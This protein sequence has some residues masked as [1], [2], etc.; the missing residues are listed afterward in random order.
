M[1]TEKMRPAF[2]A[3]MAESGYMTAK[4]MV[5]DRTESGYSWCGLYWR[6]WKES[7]AAIVIELPPKPDADTFTRVQS[8]Y[9]QGIEK[10]AG[11]ARIAGLTVKE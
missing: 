4:Q 2:E 9:W 5:E 8:A 11:Q 7:R 1:D 6:M 3:A 10:V